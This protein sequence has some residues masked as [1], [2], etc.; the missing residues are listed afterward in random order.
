MAKEYSVRGP[1]RFKLNGTIDSQEDYL[2]FCTELTKTLGEIREKSPKVRVVESYQLSFPSVQGE[3]SIAGLNFRIFRESMIAQDYNEKMIK[4]CKNHNVCFDSELP[5]LFDEL[6]S[7]KKMEVIELLTQ[8]S[9]VS[10]EIKK[11]RRVAANERKV[12]NYHAIYHPLIKTV[13]NKEKI[14]KNYDGNI[15]RIRKNFE[16]WDSIT[17]KLSSYVP[18]NQPAQV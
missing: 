12:H 1:F 8:R 2:S 9:R 15:R 3:V 11:L 18:S 17:K 13:F 14:R 4:L 6:G 7:D 10:A 16:M 5:S